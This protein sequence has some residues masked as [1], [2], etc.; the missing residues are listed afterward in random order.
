MYN[1]GSGQVE[2]RRIAKL[3]CGYVLVRRPRLLPLYSNVRAQ[4]RC[5]QTSALR[6]GNAG[7]YK[8]YKVYKDGG[9]QNQSLANRTV[10]IIYSRP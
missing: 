2:R 6:G 10:R 9:G 5:T 4:C 7:G 8:V 3:F 1:T